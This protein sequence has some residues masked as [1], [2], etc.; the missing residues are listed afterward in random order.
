MFKLVHNSIKQ[1]NGKSITNFS[2]QRNLI[3]RRS[4]SKHE[5][6]KSKGSTFTFAIPS[7]H[8]LLP[9]PSRSEAVGSAR[10]ALRTPSRWNPARWPR[11]RRRTRRT[12]MGRALPA[13]G[14]QRT[15]RQ[16]RRR[17]ADGDG[18]GVSEF[19][20]RGR[21]ELFWCTKRNGPMGLR[22]RPNCI[23]Q[24]NGPHRRFSDQYFNWEI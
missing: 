10:P 5:I 19:H 13:P 23:N 18:K 22:S 7:E 16:W 4:T 8:T 12:A 2:N 20:G 9:A 14:T 1:S 3:H 17:G 6:E 11:N 21:S 15:H 24:P